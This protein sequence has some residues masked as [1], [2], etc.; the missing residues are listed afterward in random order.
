MRNYS[1]VQT[2][3]KRRRIYS[4]APIFRLIC[5]TKAP[6]TSTA[7]TGIIATAVPVLRTSRSSITVYDSS[8]Y[9]EKTEPVGI[10]VRID[11]IS[12][13]RIIRRSTTAEIVRLHRISRI[14]ATTE[15]RLRRIGIISALVHTNISTRIPT[16]KLRCSTATTTVVVRPR[17]TRIAH[18]YFLPSLVFEERPHTILYARA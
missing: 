13:S 1:T 3:R 11:C 7:L 12:R 10:T 16:N 6:T 18:N 15:T 14:S 9:R 4:I 2:T 5:A 8:I 17:I